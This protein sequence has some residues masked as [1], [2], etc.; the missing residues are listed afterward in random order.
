MTTMQTIVIQ[1]VLFEL[2][3]DIISAPKE[4]LSEE[5][6]ASITTASPI[7]EISDQLFD[8]QRKQWKLFFTMAFR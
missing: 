7:K 2:G 5:F 8:K 6:N 3:Q 4:I 1:P